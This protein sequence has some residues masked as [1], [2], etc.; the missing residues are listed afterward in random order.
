METLQVK[1][2]EIMGVVKD[3][4]HEGNVRHITVRRD[5]QMLA[6]FPLTIGVVGAA[7]APA[8]AVFGAIAAL[9]TDCTVR[10][11]RVAA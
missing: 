2:G 9:A 4:V 1:G 8:L 7:V 10:V 5:G 3:L 11:E 6:E